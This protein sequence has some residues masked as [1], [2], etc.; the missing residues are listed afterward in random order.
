[1]ILKAAPGFPSTL[2]WSCTAA[3]ANEQ[4][5]NQINVTPFVQLSK[6]IKLRWRNIAPINRSGW[7]HLS[8]E[9][10]R[11]NLQGIF[12]TGYTLEN[13]HGTRKSPAWKE[14]LSSKPVGFILI[15][16][17]V[18]F[19]VSSLKHQRKH[20]KLGAP[21]SLSSR[22]CLPN[23]DAQTKPASNDLFV[24]SRCFTSRIYHI[25]M[26]LL[27]KSLRWI[28]GIYLGVTLSVIPTFAGKKRITHLHRK[29]L[30]HNVE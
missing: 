3:M 14:K 25:Y 1:M 23:M 28:W 24:L 15:F 29:L 7:E 12:M 20:L 19:D 21:G 10:I 13:K 27:E 17:G 18:W 8:K 4:K 2:A 22:S 16:R 6:Y 26:M 5:F 11:K 9:S 30:Q